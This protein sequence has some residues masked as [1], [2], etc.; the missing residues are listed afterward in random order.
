[1]YGLKKRLALWLAVGLVFGAGEAAATRIYHKSLEEILALGTP[2]VRATVVSSRVD[3]EPNQL[4]VQ[5]E[6]DR[7]RRLRGS[8]GQAGTVVHKFSTM[9]ERTGPD[10]QTVRV[11]PIRD[12]SGLERELQP[13]IDYFLILDAS[14]QYLIRAEDLE[15]EPRIR[16]ALASTH[17]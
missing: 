1:M 7:V 13:G 10:G 5:V 15:A 12:G 14:G 17:Q 4:S 9:L 8:V 2:V 11:S 6:I 16:E 3:I